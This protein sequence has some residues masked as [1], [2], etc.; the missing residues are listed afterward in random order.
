MTS[1]SACVQAGQDSA[2]IILKWRQ[3]EHWN[4]KKAP[5]HWHLLV[6][7]TS[8]CKAKSLAF[9][10]GCNECVKAD[11]IQRNNG[12]S[13]DTK[14]TSVW[15]LR[16]QA[17]RNK[18]NQVVDYAL[19]M[20]GRC[21]RCWQWGGADCGTSEQQ[22]QAN[23]IWHHQSQHMSSCCG[24]GYSRPVTSCG[25]WVRGRTLSHCF[26]LTGNDWCWAVIQA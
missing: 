12:V 9:S 18:H 17:H 13:R 22:V 24:S 11:I 1:V 10:F 21:L 15:R 26:S 2:Y 14:G 4:L 7:F 25:L 3:P 6:F 8:R 16:T 20:T 5:R 19:I 23:Q